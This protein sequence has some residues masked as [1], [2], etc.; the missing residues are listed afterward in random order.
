MS[1]LDRLS[2]IERDEEMRD[3]LRRAYHALCDHSSDHDN[4][5]REIKAAGV[6]DPQP[7][8]DRGAVDALREIAATRPSDV[9]AG[10]VPAMSAWDAVRR[11]QAA[12]DALG[13]R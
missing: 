8:T 11:A 4:L 9:Q 3:L 5:A 2:L 7:A 1:E 12:L 10:R 6:F 13:V